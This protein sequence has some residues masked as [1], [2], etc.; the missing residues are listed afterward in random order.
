[1]SAIPI[2][3]SAIAGAVSYN[4]QGAPVPCSI[5]DHP[6]EGHRFLPMQIGFSDAPVKLVDMASVTPTSPFSKISSMYI[7]ATNSLHDINILF[8]DTGYQT[9]IAFGD[10]AIIP[11]LTSNATPRFYVILDSGGVTS[12]TDMVN[13]FALNFYVP[14]SETEIYQRA[15]SYGYGANASLQ[16][17][18]SQS[19]TYTTNPVG[20]S[21]F[22]YTFTIIPHNQWYITGLSVTI[23]AGATNQQSNVITFYDNGVALLSYVFPSAPAFIYSNVADVAGLNIVSSGAGPLSCSI[24]PVGTSTLNFATAAINVHGGVLVP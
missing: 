6:K 17:I 14:P 2:N 7:D 8:A 4:I 10:T 3:P 22:P 5:S 1:M 20:V 12:T 21:T 18:F 9:R 11:V 19:T 13:I 24:Y 15:I 16:P 23:V